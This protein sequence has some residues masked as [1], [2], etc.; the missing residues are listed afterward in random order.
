M[1]L[2]EPVHLLVTVYEENWVSPR[3]A[4]IHLLWHPLLNTKLQDSGTGDTETGIFGHPGSGC[5]RSYG[6]VSGVVRL[7]ICRIRHGDFRN[8]YN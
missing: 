2:S 5:T 4:A 8:I 3:Y 1:K 6:A 7:T